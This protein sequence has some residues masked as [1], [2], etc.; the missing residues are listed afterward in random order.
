MRIFFVWLA[1]CTVLYAQAQPTFPYNGILPKDVTSV[2]FTHATIFTDYQTRL[3]DATLLIEKGKV[4]AVGKTL[5][6]PANAVVVDCKGKYIYPSFIDL[7]SD[8]GLAEAAPAK[9]SEGGPRMRGGSGNESPKGAFGWNDAI[10]ADYTAAL[11]FTCKEDVA[12]EMRGADRK[13]V[14]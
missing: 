13:S 9:G 4:T 12:K 2:A 3:E 6:I 14:V 1:L 10:N 11:N 5:S 7:H 8:Y